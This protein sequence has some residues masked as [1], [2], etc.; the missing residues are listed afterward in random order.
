[1]FTKHDNKFYLAKQ[2]TITIKRRKH[3]KKHTKYLNNYGEETSCSFN[4]QAA[5]WNEPLGISD[6]ISEILTETSAQ[7]TILEKIT[8]T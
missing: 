6:I 8:H 3:K 2:T 7:L 1:M 5:K 4:N